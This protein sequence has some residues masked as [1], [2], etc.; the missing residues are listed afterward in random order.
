MGLKNWR[1]WYVGSIAFWIQSLVFFVFSYFTF[2]SPSY[3]YSAW[4]L[5]FILFLLWW[6]VYLKKS[7]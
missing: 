2:F 4:S 6:Q 1:E 7:W 3:P 5:W